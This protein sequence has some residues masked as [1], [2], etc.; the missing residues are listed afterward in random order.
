MVI[1]HAADFLSLIFLVPALAFIGWLV[2]A[3]IRSDAQAVRPSGI[4]RLAAGSPLPLTR[5]RA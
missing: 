1:A 3:Q 4:D 5:L 2:A